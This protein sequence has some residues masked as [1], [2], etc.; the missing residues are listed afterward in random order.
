MEKASFDD[1]VR[2]LLVFLKGQ[3]PSLQ[4]KTSREDLI[5]QIQS[6]V[7]MLRTSIIQLE[8]AAFSDPRNT[9]EFKNLIQEYEG[10]KRTNQRL[11]ESLFLEMNKT[12]RLT[13]EMGK[14]Q[15]AQATAPADRPGPAPIRE[16]RIERSPEDQAR[17]AEL[18]AQVEELRG[19]LQ[20]RPTNA[21]GLPLD[22]KLKLEADLQ[23]ASTQT[24]ALR[25]DLE[26][27]ETEIAELKNLLRAAALENQTEKENNRLLA[28]QLEQAR[29]QI[30]T[31]EFQLGQ[32]INKPLPSRPEDLAIIRDQREEIT[33]L[34]ALLN[35]RP[36]QEDFANMQ[37]AA[38][39]KIAHL[40]QTIVEW[41]KKAEE[42]SLL[43]A[44]APEQIEALKREK[45]QLE[46]RIIDMEA[47]VRRLTA[48]REKALK[49]AAARSPALRSEEYVFFFE[50]LSAIAHRLNKSPENKDIRQKAEEAIAIL[51]KSHAIQSI[52]TIGS[53][54][55][56]KLHKVVRSFHTTLVE[57]NTVVHE[58]SRGF[59]T[60]EHV[61]QRAIVWIA[62]SRFRCTE[63]A[64]IG[65]PQDYFCHK[66][67]MELCAPDG[68]T[69]KKLSPLPAT[70]DL[71]LPLI[72]HCMTQRRIK[73]ATD[74][75]TYLAKEYP[76]HPAIQK[77]R[78]ILT[79]MAA[80]AP[81][82]PAPMPP[83]IPS[84][85]T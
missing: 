85:P 84:T 26:A 15:A 83:A 52:P 17:I 18:Q 82:P 10:L 42:R 58:V 16:V 34:Q 75:L 66:C 20:H 43:L 50:V 69:K 35:A 47:T 9:P 65:R 54:F 78:A 39:A 8:G 77:R 44:Q 56:E 55:D 38:E 5:R 12:Q 63:C 64:T 28:V 49:E 36:T 79:Q 14:L 45:M 13:A 23:S 76:D 11:E 48:S 72:D 41:K 68:T 46:Q 6:I 29:T 71:C 2:N 80:A 51:E 81:L 7:Y 30:T 1:I 67:G 22:E 60:A 3:V 74:L 32:A 4:S 33:R 40:E 73:E 31:M 24:F 62:K 57:D 70:M 19:Q 37:A 53:P 25:K 27:R 59:R 21:A 61:I